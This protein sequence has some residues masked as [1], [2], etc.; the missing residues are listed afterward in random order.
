MHVSTLDEYVRVLGGCLRLVVEYGTDHVEVAIPSLRQQRPDQR[1]EFRVIWQ[2]QESRGLVHVGWLEFTGEEYEFSYTNEAKAHPRFEP[3]PTFPLLEETYRS[4]EL[5]PFFAVRLISTADP[6]YDAVLDALGLTREDA[7]P[8]ELLAR[9]PSESPHDTIQVVPEASELPDGTL[10]RMF[11]V[12]GTR[13]AD[14]QDPRGV[15]R[16]VENLA[17]GTPLELLPEPDNPK[18]PQALQLAADGIPVGWVPDYLV[19]EIQSHIDSNRYVSF[20]VARA[21]GPDAPWH[22]RLLCRLTV[23]PVP[24]G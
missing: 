18:N 2:D 19:S 10:V 9:S 7:T 8:A 23:A 15:S 11:L 22:L 1:R 5:F 20:A 16:F 3:F 12:S 6:R 21:N 14:R 24:L 17:V 4:G 13:H